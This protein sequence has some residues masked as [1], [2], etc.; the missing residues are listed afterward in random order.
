MAKNELSPIEQYKLERA[1]AEPEVPLSQSFNPNGECN[2][3]RIG[4]RPNT[5]PNNPRWNNE[6]RSEKI[7]AECFRNPGIATSTKG[8]LPSIYANRARGLFTAG[9]KAPQA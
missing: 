9:N 3:E 8:K 4:G 7:C 5:C 6:K 1:K 2:L